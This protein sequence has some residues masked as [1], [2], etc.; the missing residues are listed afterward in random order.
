[1]E[2]AEDRNRSYQK[3]AVIG[4]ISVREDHRLERSTDSSDENIIRGIICNVGTDFVDLLQDNQKVVTVLRNR[5]K[6]VKWVEPHC[7]PC[8]CDCYECRHSKSSCDCHSVESSCACPSC[9]KV[10]H[11][12]DKHR[13]HECGYHDDHAHKANFG[14]RGR[15]HI[16]LDHERRSHHRE[17]DCTC[18]HHGKHSNWHDDHKRGHCEHGHNDWHDNHKRGHCDEHG[19]NDWHDDHKRGYHEHGHND[20]RDCKCDKHHHRG[21]CHDRHHS[22]DCIRCRRVFLLKNEF[23]HQVIPA[24]NRRVQLRLAGLTGNLSF[25]FF[26]LIGCKVEIECS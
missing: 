26:R 6:K 20:W 19:H 16:I 4:G 8:D 25:Q 23:G 2:R 17:N 18:H 21:C 24:C 1:M 13:H 10:D 11:F 7:N 9:K 15:D 5:I 3:V 12:H 22:C 14:D